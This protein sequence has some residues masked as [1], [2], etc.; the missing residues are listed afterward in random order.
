LAFAEDETRVSGMPFDA[1]DA[2]TSTWAPDGLAIAGT[3]MTRAPPFTIGFPQSMQ[4][5]D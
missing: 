5:F 3:E 4:N 2:S 1:R